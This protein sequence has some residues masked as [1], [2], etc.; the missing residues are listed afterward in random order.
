MESFQD[1]WEPMDNGWK[2]MANWILN[3]DDDDD[4]EDDD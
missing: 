2:E 1:S 3:D 4:D